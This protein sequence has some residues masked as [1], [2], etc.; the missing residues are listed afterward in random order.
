MGICWQPRV[1]RLRKLVLR[2]WC[3]NSPFVNIAVTE[4]TYKETE[5]GGKM[6][7]L[8]NSLI[9]QNSGS[10][11]FTGS[12]RFLVTNELPMSYSPRMIGFHCWWLG[13]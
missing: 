7:G 9:R 3:L 12:R 8:A 4:G 5:M 13:A 2:L 10:V 11:V 6:Q 1:V